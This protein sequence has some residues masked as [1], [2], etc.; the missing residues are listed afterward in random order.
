[1][2]LTSATGCSGGGGADGSV[3]PEGVA[4]VS[5]GEG[6]RAVWL[7]W[8]VPGHGVAGEPLN[9]LDG[10]AV[11]YAKEGAVDKESPRRAIGNVNRCKVTG[12]TEGRFVFRVT[13]LTLGGLE[14]AQSEAAAIVLE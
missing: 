13:A 12:L 5:V 14:S 10:F 4:E 3:S 7:T 2:M 1:M 9:D 6:D 11:Y 8:E